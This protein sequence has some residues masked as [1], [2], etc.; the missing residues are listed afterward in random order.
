[1]ALEKSYWDEDDGTARPRR[2]VD[3]FISEAQLQASVALLLM[4]EVVGSIHPRRTLVAFRV[5][6]DTAARH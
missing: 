6:L 5:N 1:M 4:V 3:L 2:P